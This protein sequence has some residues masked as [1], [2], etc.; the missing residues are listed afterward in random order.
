MKKTL[1]LLC[2]VFTANL[3]ALEMLALAGST[4]KD[5]LNKKLLVEAA[6]I[7]QQ[8]DC[9]A[10]VTVVDLKD[11][12]SPFY[13]GDL[14]SSGMPPKAKALRRLLVNSDVV[15]IA[16][17][18]YNSSIP[19]V[20]KNAID[21]A[22]RGEQGGASREAFQGKRF[23]IMS[24]S[25]GAG[26]GASALTHLRQI[27]SAIGGTVIEGQMALPKA[28]EAFDQEGHL[29]DASLKAQLQQLVQE[30]IEKPL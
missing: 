6:S 28:H 19:A 18:N 25:P 14:E 27:I 10:T 26:G 30:G 1:L 24:A 23:V 15:L 11:Y 20:L 2:L 7:V 9:D 12:S 3:S 22:S 16:T 13:D 5:S 29:K 21:W 8:L 17:P 4:R